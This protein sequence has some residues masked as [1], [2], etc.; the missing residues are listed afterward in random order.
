MRPYKK[1]VVWGERLINGSSHTHAYVHAAFFRA[2]QS[3]GSEVLWLSDSDD[4]SGIDFSQTLF[5]TEGMGNRLMP[6]RKDCWYVLHH[7]DFSRFKDVGYRCLNLK[8]Y[9][10]RNASLSS[11]LEKITD[12]E[13]VASSYDE[14]GFISKLLVMPW[15]TH[16]LPTE[17]ELLP[18]CVTNGRRTKSVYWV[19]SI[20]DGE[21]GNVNEIQKMGIALKSLGIEMA[22][23]RLTE[24]WE[25][26]F[27]AQ[28]SWIAPAVVGEWQR[29][30]EYLPCR[31]FKNASYCRVPVTNSD[32]VSRM[33]D[34]VP[35]VAR[36]NYQEAFM[37]C[38]EIENSTDAG[39][40]VAE[41]VKLH[42][43]YLNRIDLIE[44][45]FEW[46]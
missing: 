46:R 8:A 9:S 31:A 38:S 23:A 26:R 32:A 37:K 45:V 17:I 11:G 2:Y 15:A 25:S 19:G 6:I 16:L 29:S 12:W 30:V 42:H 13:R 21:M 44:T 33:L 35:P 4:T 5:I 27:A 34:N 36:G 28:A 3:L 41:I 20:T 10:T 18:S 43:T 22:Y 24:G 14:N 39:R 40:H 7:V 1:I